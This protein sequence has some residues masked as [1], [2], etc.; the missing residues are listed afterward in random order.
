MKVIV[1]RYGLGELES[2]WM[3]RLAE[4]SKHVHDS[5]VHLYVWKSCTNELRGMYSVV[6]F[7]PIDFRSPGHRC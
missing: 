4:L 1:V 2:V 7:G 5:Y 6:F 3:T